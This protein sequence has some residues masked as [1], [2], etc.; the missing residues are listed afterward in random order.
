MIADRAQS[1]VE[2]CDIDKLNDLTAAETCTSDRV[3]FVRRL[4]WLNTFRTA[5]EHAADRLV[6]EP[7]AEKYL[8]DP[9][10]EWVYHPPYW[11]QAIIYNE[12][13]H[14]VNCFFHYCRDQLSREIQQVEATHYVTLLMLLTRD[15]IGSLPEG[16]HQ[17]LNQPEYRDCNLCR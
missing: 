4:W 10:E 11:E 9:N 15:Y 12:P 7:F 6:P 17:L 8:W 13:A 14:V 5:P 16:V 1:H 3:E 2:L